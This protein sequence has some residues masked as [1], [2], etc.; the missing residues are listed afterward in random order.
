MTLADTAVAAPWSAHPAAPPRCVVVTGPVGAGKT[1]WLQ[2]CVRRLLQR[3]PSA[4]P[5]VLLAEEGR[6]RMENFCRETPVVAWRKLVLPCTCCP[7]AADLPDAVRALVGP[8][9]ADWL[10]LE[11]PVIAAPGLLGEFDRILGWSRSL[12]ACLTPRW[13]QARTAEETSPFLSVLFGQAD[14]VIA[15]P[16]DAER[17]VEHLISEMCPP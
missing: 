8:A 7:A 1:R 16:A 13:A 2:C 4:R 12:V 5:A 14:I 9:R 10:F 15:G 3:Q 17:A 11:L 6:T